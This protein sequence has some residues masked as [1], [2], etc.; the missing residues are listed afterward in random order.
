MTNKLEISRFVNVYCFFI[1]TKKV[2]H[3]VM[4]SFTM[5]V[6]EEAVLALSGLFTERKGVSIS[7]QQV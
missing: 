3:V 1:T 6:A 4:V 2:I 7:S 5:A